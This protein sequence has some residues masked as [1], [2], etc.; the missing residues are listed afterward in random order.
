LTHNQHISL[1]IYSSGAI[2]RA[3]ND[4]GFSDCHISMLW[5][6]NMLMNLI[7]P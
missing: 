7:L 5:A 6:A 2:Y 3:V 4:A 1:L